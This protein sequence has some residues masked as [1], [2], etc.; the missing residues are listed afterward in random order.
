MDNNKLDRS[1][2]YDGPGS[3]ILKQA[4]A[5]TQRSLGEELSQLNKSLGETSKPQNK[6]IALEVTDR[7]YNKK[8]IIKMRNKNSQ[9]HNKEGGGGT[10]TK[11]SSKAK[12][13]RQP[14]PRVHQKR[15]EYLQANRLNEKT[16]KLNSHGSGSHPDPAKQ[17]KRQLLP[18]GAG[19]NKLRLKD[20]SSLADRVAKLNEV[21]PQPGESSELN[22]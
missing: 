5:M 3:C 2:D 22:A 16:G 18:I 15:N 4:A 7:L 10:K 19:L 9:G 1:V 13:E 8:S 21:Q 12:H 17:Q 20:A 6:Q 14:S 11:G